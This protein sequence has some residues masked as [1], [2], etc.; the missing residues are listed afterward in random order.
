MDY[1]IRKRH[2]RRFRLFLITTLLIMAFIFY[3]SSMDRADSSEMSRG[4]LSSLIGSLLSRLLPRLSEKGAEHDLRKY[5]HLFEFACLGASSVSLLIE[6][7]WLRKGRGPLGAAALT[8]VVFCALYAATDEWHQRFVPGRSGQL[9][10]ILV[11][12][13]GALFGI[14]LVLT[15][16]WLSR[17]RKKAD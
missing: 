16:T 8:A 6:A 17:R 1:A 11:D 5:A 13:G 12:T 10:D 9:S 2:E 7:A 14:L 4:F 3:M 15:G